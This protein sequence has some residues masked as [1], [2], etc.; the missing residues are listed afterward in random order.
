MSALAD[1]TVYAEICFVYYSS[2]QTVHSNMYRGVSAELACGV[3]AHQK[4]TSCAGPVLTAALTKGFIVRVCFALTDKI[5]AKCH[6]ALQVE[7]LNG[8]ELSH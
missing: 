6:H 2:V 1:T 8:T 3:Y 4:F 5:M 7:Y